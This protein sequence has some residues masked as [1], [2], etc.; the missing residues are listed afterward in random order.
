M[1]SRDEE[2]IYRYRSTGCKG[3]LD[4]LVSLHVAKVRA[5]VFPMVLDD[6]AADDLTQDV[7]LR[8]FRSLSSFDGRSQFTT[9][10]YRIAMNVAY[11]YLRRSGRSPVV[12]RAE[13]PET[14]VAQSSPEQ[15]A[16]QNEM[17]QD[18]EMALAALSP[19]LRA[20]IVLTCLNGKSASEAAD[21]ERCSTATMYGR[22]HEARKQLE[23]RLA[24][25]LT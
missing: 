11:S 4:E 21:I 6:A 25:H 1:T 16:V 17:E 15:T 3:S 2:L 9:W 24:R 10:L 18:I 13:V 7:L 12:F 5:I 23:Q 20:A 14:S 22:V 8:V 19:K